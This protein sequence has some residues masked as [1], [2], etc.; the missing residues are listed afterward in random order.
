MS[1]VLSAEETLAEV[2]PLT[3][4]RLE[5]WVRAEVVRPVPGPRGPAFRRLDVARLRL[6]CELSDEFALEDDALALVLTLVD[7]L[8]RAE[9]ELSALA[10]ALAEQPEPVRRRVGELLREHSAG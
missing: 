8:Q 7:R 4:A 3:R 1:D 6:A 2:P 9:A 10:G 5:T